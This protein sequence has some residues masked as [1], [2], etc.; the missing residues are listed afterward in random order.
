[1]LA[2]ISSK[3]QKSHEHLKH[4]SEI[5]MHLEK[6]YLVQIHYK[7][8]NTSMELFRARMVEGSNNDI[9]IDL[10]LQSLSNSFDQCVMNF[11]MSKLEVMVNE[12]MKMFLMTDSPMKKDKTILVVSSS[13]AHKGKIGEKKKKGSFSKGKRVPKLFG[14]IK[15]K[16]NTKENKCFYCGEIGHWKRNCKKYLASLKND[17]F[18][19]EVNLSINNDTRV[20][21]TVCGS[22][23]CNSLQGI[24]RP[25]RLSKE[26]MILRMKNG[27]S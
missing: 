9:Y 13:K 24:Q 12:L 16:A 7:L 6:L 3:R 27:A 20:F 2:S 10:I 5:H 23:L 15:N 26:D 19:G 22:P 18:F 1:M 25:K 14:G 11:N 8:F 17:M 21:A 4:A